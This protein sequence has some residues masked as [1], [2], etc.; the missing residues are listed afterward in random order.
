MSHVKGGVRE[1][2]ALDSSIGCANLK[3]VE[4]KSDQIIL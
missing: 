4:A 1:K 3:A 2:L